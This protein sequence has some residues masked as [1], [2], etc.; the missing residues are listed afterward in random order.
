MEITS[1][2]KLFSS[3]NIRKTRIREQVLEV[4][5]NEDNALTNQDIELGLVEEIDRI[6]LYRTLNLFVE[7][8]ILHR[9]ENANTTHYALCN[10]CD[11]H[12]HEDD[13]LHFQCIKCDTIECFDHEEQ[14]N[15]QLPPNYKVK[16]M[17]VLLKGLCAKCG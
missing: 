14:F 12:H 2:E 8:G 11:M 3:H 17:N 1:V 6:T 15:I 16:E 5:L 7:Q 10:D 4:F 9:I 13:H